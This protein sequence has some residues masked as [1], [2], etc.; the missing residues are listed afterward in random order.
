[1]LH[2]E[3]EIVNAYQDDQRQD[4]KQ[5]VFQPFQADFRSIGRKMLDLPLIGPDFQ[6]GENP[7][8]QNLS[9]DHYQF[10]LPKNQNISL[11]FFQNKDDPVNKGNDQ[12]N[13]VGPPEPVSGSDKE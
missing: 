2:A 12:V 13:K 3:N 10:E 7:V 8:K 1:M 11:L 6:H 5:D 9:D 4:Q